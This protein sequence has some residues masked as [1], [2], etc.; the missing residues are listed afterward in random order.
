M[1][2]RDRRCLVRDAIDNSVTHHRVSYADQRAASLPI[3]F[4]YGSPVGNAHPVCHV[5]V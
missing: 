2:R 4:A 3:T 5:V 1:C